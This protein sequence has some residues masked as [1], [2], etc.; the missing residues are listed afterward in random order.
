VTEHTAAARDLRAR[1]AQSPNRR[2]R[3]TRAALVEAYE[4][5]RAEPGSRISVAALVDRANVNRTTFYAHFPSLTALAAASRLPA[6][7]RPPA[8]Q[9]SAL[10]A[11]APRS[12]L[13]AAVLDVAGHARIEDA[14][15]SQIVRRAGV[16]RATFYKH[17]MN[18]VALLTQV[19]GEEITAVADSVLGEARRRR[20]DPRAAYEL[21][22]RA[23]MTHV[24]AHDAVYR[25]GLG[26]EP[27]SPG[28]LLM[29]CDHFTRQ[30]RGILRPGDGGPGAPAPGDV[31]P[32]YDQPVVDMCIAHAAY[33][34]VGLLTQWLRSGVKDPEPLL[35]VATNALPAFWFELT[36]DDGHAPAATSSASRSSSADLA[37][38]PPM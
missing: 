18:P 3:D 28:L 22:A 7:T 26:R 13:R 36:G 17:A 16:T 30:L 10:P 34:G 6:S 35:H 27:S 33:G 29:L 25:T 20:L 14:V 21:T 38:R 12:R 5:L 9:W 24:T 4:A 1:M 32:G 23:F 2:A 11:G 31:L 19:L 8:G 15:V 37:V